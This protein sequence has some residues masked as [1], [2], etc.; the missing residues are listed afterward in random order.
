MTWDRAKRE[1]VLTVTAALCKHYRRT[2]SCLP[3]P[4]HHPCLSLCTVTLN[5]RNGVTPAGVNDDDDSK[6]PGVV[7]NKIPEGDLLLQVSFK[8]VFI[9]VQYI[10]G[11]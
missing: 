2:K 6:T 7:E 9:L 10:E 5:S 3:L 8:A 11:P 4:A 1:A